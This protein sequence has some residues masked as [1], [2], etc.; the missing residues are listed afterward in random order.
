M[1]NSF[2]LLLVLMIAFQVSEA[3]AQNSNW[4]DF[5]DERNRMSFNTN[6]GEEKDIIAGDVDRD[7]DTD[8]IV[9][10]K[11]P[12]SVPGARA[13]LLLL[14]ED[15]VL[16]DRTSDY[17]PTFT[18]DPG[19]DRDVLLFDA[20]ND[21][22]LDIVTVTTFDDIPRL[23]INQGV[24]ANFDWQGYVDTPNWYSPAFPEGPRFCAVA[25][26]DV[27]NDGF[28]DLFFVDYD[29]GLEN[30]L[31]INDGDGTFTDETDAR[32]SFD[33]ST[34]GFGT[35]AFITDFNYDGFND[36]VSL[37]STVEGGGTNNGDGFGIEFCINDGTGNF[38]QVQVLP[39]DLTY[40]M[41]L[42]DY[43]NDGRDDLYVVSDVQDYIIYNNSTNANG[44]IQ[45]S[46]VNVASSGLTANFSGN[47]HA[48][49]VNNDGLI[50]MAVC[51][52]DVDIPGCNRR[53]ALLQNNGTTMIDPNNAINPLGYNYRGS[54]DMCWLD[55]N[56][57]GNLDIFIA[58]C[59]DYHMLVNDADALF[60]VP[61]NF[62]RFRGFEIDAQLSH[63]QNSDDITASFNPGFTLTN[64]EAPIWLIFDGNAPTADS[65]QVESRA[66]TP[67]LTYTVEFANYSQGG[68]FEVVDRVD[69]SFNADT[70]SVSTI[71]ADHID[72]DGNV[73]ARVGW[74]Q[75]GFVLIFPWRVDVDHVGWNQN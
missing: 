67:N 47:V 46:V 5:V 61:S 60:V 33:A 27:N 52:V 39:S 2:K 37:E 30:R 48:A 16:F 1:K 35:Q 55:I 21:G 8:V 38:N 41:E 73:Q 72:T 19:D 32:L 42:A 59:D 53:F 51:D 63:F 58:T 36:I 65:F 69:E 4:V 44:T 64:L 12:F 45:H 7:G 49:D 31:L 17:I 24:D 22:W 14:N 25:A 62:V 57:D 26:G 34:V 28:Q 54:H 10:R 50:D 3:F 56:N 23:Y 6:D 40:M 29:N 66:N 71:T 68:Q 9:V 18:T 74:R 70:V 43:D 75:A 15:G 13:N 20:N 11:F